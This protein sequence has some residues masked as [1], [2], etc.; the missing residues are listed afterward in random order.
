MKKSPRTAG[1]LAIVAA[2]LL[3]AS[4]R[5]AEAQ[6]GGIGGFGGIG[7]GLGGGA[8]M[9]A[10]AA[11]GATGQ[12]PRLSFAPWLSANGTYSDA[13]LSAG[14]ATTPSRDFYGYGGAAGMSG[15]RAWT[16]TSLAGFYTGSYQHY[17]GNYVR[18]GLS[19]AGGLSVQHKAGEKV[20]IF[21][22]QFAG[23]SNG[24]YGYGAGAGAFGG[25]NMAGTGV[26]SDLAP[27]GLGFGDPGSNGLVDNEVTSTR[28][29]FTGTSGGVT[30][31][32]NMRWTYSVFGSGAFVRR[33]ANGLSDLNSFS[34]GGQASY[35]LD[36]KTK[37]GA[38][39]TYGRFSYPNLFGGNTVQ[40]TGLFLTHQITPETSITVMAGGYQFR[41]NALGRVALDPGLAGLLGQSS[42]LEVRD[43]QR[44]GWI[45]SA[46]VSRSWRN[47]SARLG[48]NRSAGPGNG[49]I[50]ASSRDMA[51]GSLTS[52]VGRF[53]YGAYA[54]YYMFKGI[55]QNG[56][57]TASFS[58]AGTCGVRMFGD[59]YLGF[60]AGYSR[61]ETNTSAEQWRRFL[62]AHLTWSPKDAAF[63][64]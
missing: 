53:S 42:V 48:Y 16:R 63:R 23:S 29:N 2:V 45:G 57:N 40:Q 22:T 9:G 47:W 18:K 20:T 35:L 10:G 13:L 64:F 6:Y 54:S 39:Y 14:P 12:S 62:S 50:L 15:G 19:Q 26:L 49:L 27:G 55:I 1:R 5:P 8:G 34:G 41:T 31:Q 56:A 21:A 30:Y 52:G 43:I 7:T 32:P 51:M 61:F 11:G 4:V 33:S 3:A 36:Q 17:Q 58:A 59:M 28:V 25:W 46:T 37:L 44:M 24:G 38:F 60:S